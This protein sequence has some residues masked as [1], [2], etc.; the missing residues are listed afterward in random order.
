LKGRV[1]LVT[2]G[3]SGIG[4]ATAVGLAKLGADMVLLCRNRERAEAARREIVSESGSPSVDVIIADLLIQ[5]EVRRAAAEFL[6]SRTRLDVLIN[7]AGSI[8]SG[9]ALTEDGI[10]R[11]MEV[12]YFAPFL[13][14]NLLLKTLEGSAPSRVVN[15]SSDSHYGGRLSLN[16]I[17]G[18]GKMGLGGLGAY[19]R[20]KLALNLFTFELARREE[21]KDVTAN[22]LHPGA[23]RTKI[24]TNQGAFTPVTR[25]ISAFLMEPEE[26]AKTSIYLAS[27]PDV[28][29]VTGKYFE[30]CSEKMPSAESLDAKLASGL[31]D[32]SLKMTGLA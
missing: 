10:E 6:S 20:S 27:S 18:N 15:V 3:S 8:F 31:W 26:G 32:L 25:L 23:V 2:G 12:N 16:D 21:R 19:G 30:K 5:K 14:T 13:L 29:R 4:K 9:Y 24:W 7:N 11:T 22:A 17:N 1:V 28:E